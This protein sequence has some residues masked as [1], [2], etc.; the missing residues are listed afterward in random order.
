VLYASE[1]VHVFM[2]VWDIYN[3]SSARECENLGGELKKSALAKGARARDSLWPIEGRYSLG[4]CNFSFASTLRSVLLLGCFMA[5]LPL[6]LSLW[7][8]M[9]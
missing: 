6:Q 7:Q 1:R 9:M 8:V 3:S 5:L 2:A 4:L